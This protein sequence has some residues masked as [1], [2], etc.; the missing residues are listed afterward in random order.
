M[1]SRVDKRTVN[2][3]LIAAFHRHMSLK[4]KDEQCGVVEEA[5]LLAGQ[6]PPVH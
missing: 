6:I 4:G 1:R 5:G 2:V 3:K